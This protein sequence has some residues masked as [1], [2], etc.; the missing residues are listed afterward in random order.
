MKTRTRTKQKSSAA[1]TANTEHTTVETKVQPSSLVNTNSRTLVPA[2]RPSRTFILPS[3]SSSSSAS[4]N[5]SSDEA[6]RFLSLPSPSTGALN[7]YYFSPTLG[8]YEFTVVASSPQLPRSILFAPAPPSS[9]LVVREELKEGKEIEDQRCEHSIEGAMIAKNAELLIAT[10]IDA[11]FF[12]LPILSPP[13]L[14]SSPASP[15]NGNYAVA[16][17]RQQQRRRLFQSLDDALDSQQLHEQPVSHLRHVL[18]DESFRPVLA[19][20]TETV[21]DV[22]E[23]G[24]EKMYRLNV[25]KLAREMV[26]KARRMSAQGLPASLEERFVRQALAAPLP[27]I[28]PSNNVGPGNDDGM[29]FGSTTLDSTD[30]D[31]GN[32]KENNTHPDHIDMNGNLSEPLS[33]TRSS[34]TKTTTNPTSTLPLAESTPVPT[35][36]SATRLPADDGNKNNNSEITQLLRIRVALSFIQSSYLPAHL[37]ALVDEALSSLDSPIDFAPLTA[38]LKRVAELRAEAQAAHAACTDITLK[39]RLDSNHLDEE[40]EAEKKRRK[41]EEEEKK[42]NTARSESRAVRELR[43]VDTSGMKKMTAFFSKSAS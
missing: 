12:M 17:G 11:L 4:C 36:A 18:Y 5:P 1:T 25:K 2:E 33:E 31:D 3:P 15:S 38:H 21:C 30:N 7:Q 35:P 34:S 28:K 42:K 19:R 24:G 29:K 32:T 6:G 9:P 10:P 22:V 39:R 37:V 8:L 27:V 14:A 20:R 23:A 26:S 40:E 13:P 16:T 41:R 43:K